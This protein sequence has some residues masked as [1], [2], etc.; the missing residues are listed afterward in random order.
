MTPEQSKKLTVGAR[1]CFNGDQADSGTVKATNAKYVTIKW[2]DG[3]QSFTGQKE[4]KR[5]ESVKK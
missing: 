5:V 4:M 2:N 3:H 1:V